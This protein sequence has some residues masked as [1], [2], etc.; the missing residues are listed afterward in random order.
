LGLLILPLVTPVLIFGVNIVQQT[1]AG[2]SVLGPLAFLAG[3]S[4]FTITL[5]P[6]AVASTLRISQDD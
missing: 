1:Q 5:L 3:L 6:W 4:L 2:L